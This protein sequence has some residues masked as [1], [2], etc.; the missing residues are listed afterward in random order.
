MRIKISLYL[1]IFIFFIGT[2]CAKEERSQKVNKSHTQEVALKGFVATKTNENHPGSPKYYV[3][4]AKETTYAISKSVYDEL[5]D[6][7]GRDVVLYGTLMGGKK[8]I[9]IDYIR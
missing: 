2:V 9:K 7:I 4:I 5:K 8:I 1:F 3:F 6:D